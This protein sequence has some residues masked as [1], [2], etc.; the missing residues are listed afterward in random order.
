GDPPGGLGVD[1]LRRTDYVSP[2][3][4]LFTQ[5]HE[6]VADLDT[7][8]GTRPGSTWHHV[9]ARA[10]PGW[11]RMA[12]VPVQVNA[13]LPPQGAL[14]YAFADNRRSGARTPPADP[15]SHL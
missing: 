3:L 12:L 9:P 13:L 15:A 4:A 5:G 10:A 2:N 1:G 6:L 7:C 11:S 8:V 14:A